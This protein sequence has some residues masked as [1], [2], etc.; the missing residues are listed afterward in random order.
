M[1]VIYRNRLTGDAKD[2]ASKGIAKAIQHGNQAVVQTQTARSNLDAMQQQLTYQTNVSLGQAQKNIYQAQRRQRADSAMLGFAGE[3]AAVRDLAAVQDQTAN[4]LSNIINQAEQGAIGI[5]TQ[6][7][8][9]NK[10]ELQLAQAEV[11]DE[12]A[13]DLIR[14][15]EKDSSANNGAVK[16]DTGRMVVNGLTGALTGAIKGALGASFFSSGLKGLA[17]PNSGIIRKTIS[18]ASALGS[19]GMFA[20]DVGAAVNSAYK[21]YQPYGTPDIYGADVAGTVLGSTIGAGIGLGGA[22]RAFGKGS[23]VVSPMMAGM[24]GFV[25]GVDYG[26]MAG[27]DSLA[28]GGLELA[29]HSATGTTLNS[30]GGL[31]GVPAEINRGAR[32]Y[33]KRQAFINSSFWKGGNK[34]AAR[35][36][37]KGATT[38]EQLAINM[39]T[40][41]KNAEGFMGKAAG[42]ASKGVGLLKT[43][44]WVAAAMAGLGA[45]FGG[46]TSGMQKKYSLDL[47]KLANTE[48]YQQFADMD[49]ALENLTNIVYNK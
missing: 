32:A 14:D 38:G 5:A 17:N 43:N 2:I 30:I 33:E 21:Y 49:L 16:Q 22:V 45:V 1:A 9:L 42:V 6:Q 4:T 25:D 44:P 34:A 18:G 31:R 12:Y 41:S 11:L 15:Y 24:S 26:A 35:A 10:Q 7:S 36:A 20:N 3:V 47:D 46:I 48:T 29:K 8:A 39:L 19:L 40:G 37:T 28:G 27:L 23:R 13:N